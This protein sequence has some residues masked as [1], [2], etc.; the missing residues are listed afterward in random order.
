[1]DSTPARGLDWEAAFR[2]RSTAHLPPSEDCGPRSRP[3]VSVT[4]PGPGPQVLRRP[5]VP[6]VARAR[7]PASPGQRQAARATSYPRRPQRD[8]QWVS[9]NTRRA[10]GSDRDI[11]HPQGCL[12]GT[13]VPRH[14]S[15]G[16]SEAHRQRCR[17][18]DGGLALRY[19][20]RAGNRLGLGRGMDPCASG[21]HQPLERAPRCWFRLASRGDGPS[22]T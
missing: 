1:M 10:D 6:T 12:V 15:P 2:Q 5:H 18:A 4:T 3:P 19:E 16:L 14:G 13:S 7:R 11:C 22:Q 9:D 21:W 20:P 8:D 17:P